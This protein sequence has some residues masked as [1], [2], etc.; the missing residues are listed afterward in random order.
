M[1]ELVLKGDISRKKLDSIVDF[2]R[3]WDI[4]VEIK[5]APSD[6]EDKEALFASSFG[7]W[8]NRDIDIKAMRKESR[9]RRTK[10]YDNG[11]L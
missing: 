10:Q 2:L 9:E 1:T 11:T 7:M 4:E 6:K 8:E 5:S 3:S